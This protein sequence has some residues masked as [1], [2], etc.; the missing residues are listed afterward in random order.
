MIASSGGGIDL[1][2][3]L[4]D[5]L[6]ILA[7]AKVLAEVAERLKIPAVLG[8]ILA[9]VLVGPSVLGLVHLDGSRGVSLAVIAEIGVLLLL[10]QVGMEMDLA[11]LGKVGKASLLVAL[12]GVAAPFLLSLIHI[13]EPTR[14]Y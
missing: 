9:G 11:E 13:S 8:E 6:V 7:G 14:P 12:I 5:L 1:A 4:L 3:L 10:L 2:R